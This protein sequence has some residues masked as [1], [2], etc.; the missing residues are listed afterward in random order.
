M[1]HHCP[2]D[3]YQDQDEQQRWQQCLGA[4]ASLDEDMEEHMLIDF[5]SLSALSEF[6]VDEHQ[7]FTCV[8]F[9]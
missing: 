6:I 1:S 3:P 7:D 9:P 4:T 8:R 5:V 2:R